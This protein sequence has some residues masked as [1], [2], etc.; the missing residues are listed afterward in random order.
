MNAKRSRNRFFKPGLESSSLS[1]PALA[2]VVQP[3]STRDCGS[4][5]VG[6]NPTAR[7]IFDGSAKNRQD[8][9][10]QQDYKKVFLSI[11]FIV[12]SF[13]AQDSRWCN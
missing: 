10:D 13:R 6:S 5:D 11:L 3:A 1:I 8:L 9:Q 4:R 2:S 7:T 12:S